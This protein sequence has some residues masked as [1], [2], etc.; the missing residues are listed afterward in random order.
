M[1]KGTNMKKLLLALAGAAAFAFAGGAQAADL[2]LKAAPA[3]QQDIS[4]YMGLYIGTTW[5]NQNLPDYGARSEAFVFGGEG[6][7]NY[8]ISPTLSVQMDAEA[9]VT[10]AINNPPYDST[11]DNDGRVHGV[12]GGHLAMRNP[13]SHAIAVFGGLSAANNLYHWGGSGEGQ[14]VHGLIGLEG[15]LYFNQFTLYGQG[16]YAGRITGSDTT[17]PEHLWFIRGVGRYFYT[18]NDKIQAEVGYAA[19]PAYNC[20]GCAT[21]SITNWG[22]LYEHRFDSPFSVYAEYAGFSMDG[23]S[24]RATEH[25]VMVGIKAYVNQGTLLAN[26]RNGA[27]FDMPKFVRALPWSYWVNY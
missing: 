13:A 26:D 21:N 14:M 24:A 17:E 22:V 18:P 15:Q 5:F 27:T 1:T 20:S 2:P 19:G 7:V 12:F 6:R 16:G 10:T 9:E 3:A 25:M 8:W 23:D 4:G 11:T